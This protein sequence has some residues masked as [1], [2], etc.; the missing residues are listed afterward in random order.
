MPVASKG[1]DFLKSS[2]SLQFIL[3]LNSTVITSCLPDVSF[4][5]IIENSRKILHDLRQLCGFPNILLV[6]RLPLLSFVD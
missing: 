2:N 5:K 6:T 1:A 4:L 3:A